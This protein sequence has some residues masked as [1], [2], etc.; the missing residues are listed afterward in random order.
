[1][2]HKRHGTTFPEYALLCIIGTSDQG[3][4]KQDDAFR[5]WKGALRERS[6]RFGALDT[7]RAY[8]DEMVGR[9]IRY[10]WL[11]RTI[12]SRDLMVTNYGRQTANNY[13]D[14]KHDSWEY[15]GR[16]WEEPKKPQWTRSALR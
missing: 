3:K 11:D 9:L 4:L 7:S 15:A 8:F 1:M 2:K 12:F 14:R 6:F 13:F 10:G 16:K 5:E